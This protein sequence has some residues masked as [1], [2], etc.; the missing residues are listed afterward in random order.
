MPKKWYVGATKP[1]YEEIFA[2]NSWSQI[3]K[4]CQKNEV[5]SAWT[6]GSQKSMV[7]NGTSYKV[8]IIGKNHD[9]Y[10]DGS[11]KAPLTFQLHDCYGSSYPM[12]NSI[13]NSG[14]WTSCVMRT[15]H[16]PAILALMPTEVQAGIKEVSK[17]TSAGN[18]S[19]T[20]NT[21]ADKLFLLS[22]I[23][24]FGK[25]NNSA[26]G[27]GSQYEYYALGNTATKNLHQ[28]ERSPVVANATHFGLIYNGNMDM[29]G[30][31]T[32]FGISFA[33]CFGGTS[34]VNTDFGGGS[35]II[36]EVKKPYIGLNKQRGLPSGYTELTYIQSSGT[37][38][39]DTG[40]KA[41]QNTKMVLDCEITYGTGW[42]MIAGSYDS[43]A[44]YSWWAKASQMYVYYVS[45][46]KNVVGTS[47]RMMLTADKN[48]WTAGANAMSFTAST[49]AAT[50]PI[51]LCSV[52]GG[53]SYENA[54]MKIYSCK[55]YDNGTLVRD[56]VPCKNASGVVGLYDMVNG[57]FYSNAGS[58]SFSP[59]YVVL[60]GGI[61]REVK[62]GYIGVDNV[63][64]LFFQKGIP[65]GS[66]PVGQSIWLNE[67]GVPTEFFIVHQGNP[68][69]SVYDASC[70]G[71]WLLRKKRFHIV[72]ADCGGKA[73]AKGDYSYEQWGLHDYLTNTYI[74]K[75]DEGI[76]NIVKTAKIPYY[77]YLREYDRELEL[78]VMR[79]HAW[80]QG[81]DGLPVKFFLPSL[82]EFCNYKEYIPSV[83]Y[84]T[85]DYF[86]DVTGRNSQIK[87]HADASDG[88]LSKSYIFRMVTISQS[89][90]V[91][92]V[93]SQNSNSYASADLAS[94]ASAGLRPM[95]IVP[96][97][98]LVNP[99]TYEILV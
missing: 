28:W 70:T 24:F 51:Y 82:D 89:S 66:L 73:V 58:G 2:N 7:I 20:I 8:D 77:Y 3:I 63:A 12:N 80:K 76:R 65:I 98:T 68:N 62:K 13:T 35:P 64:R 84:A 83:N 57:T 26:S 56:F 88:S 16:L 34:E 55:I 42:I 95:C 93:S 37:Q 90:G 11:G 44:H 23:E 18:K 25:T 59:G 6:V 36:R 85:L 72:A 92:N 38:Y 33:F 27:E 45:A 87:F 41:N 97:E 50:S 96:Q 54:T 67:N 19:T 81:A 4:A 29:N 40:F 14:G 39:I 78:D 71:T 75:F 69:T 15:T 43:G 74:N 91:D 31:A 48:T 49:F 53:G 86:L 94:H 22:E 1:E 52:N 99:A 61:A 47:G 60:A 10:A 79:Y 30:A 21:T 32:P 17:K 9:D 5:P 46:N